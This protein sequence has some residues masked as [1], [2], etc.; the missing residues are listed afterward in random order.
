MA[1]SA[2][3]GASTYEIKVRPAEF[4]AEMGILGSGNKQVAVDVLADGRIRASRR[5]VKKD[6]DGKPIKGVFLLI[7]RDMSIIPLTLLSSYC[8]FM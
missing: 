8:F 1:G 4:G 2:F 7:W 6:A 5:I 3:P